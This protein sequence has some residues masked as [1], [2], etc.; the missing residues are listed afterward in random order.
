MRKDTIDILEKEYNKQ[1][2]YKQYISFENFLREAKEIRKAILNKKLVIVAKNK[3]YTLFDV[4]YLRNNH[5]ERLYP[6][7]KKIL[8]PYRVRKDSQYINVTAIGT[9]KTF[10]IIYNMWRSLWLELS[11]IPQYQ[12]IL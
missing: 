9:S 11:N 3:D 10:E 4:Y 6:I 1:K 12:I 7:S 5:I 8:Q 2:E